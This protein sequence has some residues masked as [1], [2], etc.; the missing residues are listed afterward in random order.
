MKHLLGGHNRTG[1]ATQPQLAAAMAA[2]TREFAPSSAG[3]AQ[4]IAEEREHYARGGD[5]VGTM[6][7]PA[8]VKEMAKTAVRTMI[9]EQPLLLLD[10][11]G[12]RLAF[13]RA[14]TRLYE[15]LLSKHDSRRTFTGGPSRDEIAHIR[16]EELQHMHLVN[17]A[18][19]NLGGDPTAVTPSAN[20]QATAS[21]GFCA[22]LADPR[23]DVQQGLEVLLAAELIDN[24]CWA[25]LIELTEQAGHDELATRFRKAL[26]EERAHLEHVRRW[27]ATATGRSGERALLTGAETAREPRTTGSTHRRGA[28]TAQARATGRPSAGGAKRQSHKGKAA[29]SSGT[30]KHRARR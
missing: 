3:D 17:D 16:D 28:R 10:K 23:T 9:G 4:A 6:P 14:G 11:L 21:Q 13:E 8:G 30:S 15:A 18:I 1:A 5:V 24:D 26:D 20:L 27:L 2:A 7:P 22:V 12:E 19:A 25:S 29:R